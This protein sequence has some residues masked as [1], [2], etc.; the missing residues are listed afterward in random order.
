ME[1]QSVGVVNE[2]VL[3]SN[4]L[5]E[6]GVKTFAEGVGING[7]IS[8]QGVNEIEGDHVVVLPVD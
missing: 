4:V 6:S 7:G 8:E 5:S 3:F 2:M 1:V